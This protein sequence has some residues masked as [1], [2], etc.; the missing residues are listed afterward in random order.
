MS[1]FSVKGYVRKG[2]LLKAMQQYDK[3]MEAF[4]KAIEIDENYGVSAGDL[5]ALTRLCDPGA[6]RH[7]FAGVFLYIFIVL[8]VMQRI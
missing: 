3:A 4:Q 1:V 6:F 8:N 5:W 2:V 7:L